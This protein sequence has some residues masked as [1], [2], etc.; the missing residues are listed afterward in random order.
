MSAR[1]LVEA[2]ADVRLAHVFNPYADRC[3]TYDRANAPQLR[4]RALRA[5]LEAVRASGTDTVW[6]GRDLGYKGGR[7]TGLALTDEHHLHLLATV[8]PGATWARATHGP[9]C[10]ERTATE[11][12]KC[13]AALATPPLLWNVFPLHPHEPEQPFT[14]R[15]F[16]A[17]ELDAVQAINSEL[18]AWLG[19]TR[20]VALGQDAARYAATFGLHVEHVRHP[21]YG[22]V[23]E[24]RASIRSLYPQTT[25]QADLFAPPSLV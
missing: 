15:K 13:L 23:T 1:R 2:L 18:L 19:V 7:R 6:M 25:A 3:A 9:A 21:S 12:W 14:N 16:A 5:Y 24:F 4:R 10:I 11:I 22:G 20:V 8:Y 17:R